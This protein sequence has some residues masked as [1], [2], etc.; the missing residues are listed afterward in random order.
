MTANAVWV[1]GN[2]N[3]GFES[4]YNHADV[5]MTAFLRGPCR[6]P[7]AALIVKELEST[8]SQESLALRTSLSK[9]VT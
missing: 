8:G 1:T 5:L 3:R 6:Y 9:Q 2:R 4:G 7:L